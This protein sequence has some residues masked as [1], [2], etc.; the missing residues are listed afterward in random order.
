MPARLTPREMTLLSSSYIAVQGRGNGQLQG[1]LGVSGMCPDSACVAT[2]RSVRLFTQSWEVTWGLQ[3]V[4]IDN[5]SIIRAN[6]GDRSVPMR[7]TMNDDNTIEI[8][9]GDLSYMASGHASYAIAGVTLSEGYFGDFATNTELGMGHIDWDHDRLYL[10]FPL[11]FAGVGASEEGL[12]HIEAALGND[13]PIPGFE[14]S[15]SV[16]CNPNGTRDWVVNLH[17]TSRDLDGSIVEWSWY[18]GDSYGTAEDHEFV[19]HDPGADGFVSLS[20]LDNEGLS[21][22][23]LST[24]FWHTHRSWSPIGQWSSRPARSSWRTSGSND[25]R[26]QHHGLQGLQGLH[27]ATAR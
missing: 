11:F 6:R 25:P 9:P 19:F 12:I 23:Q 20:V 18:N 4:D 16:V 21:E 3:E 14:M 7:L 2:I 5:L 26:E 13:P 10:D 8:R 22:E 1:T 27:D 15:D 17:D 24:R